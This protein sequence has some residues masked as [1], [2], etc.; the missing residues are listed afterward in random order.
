M[1]FISDY[2]MRETLYKEIVRLLHIHRTW[3]EVIGSTNV[4]KH[5]VIRGNRMTDILCRML[6]VK[7]IYSCPPYRKGTMWQIAEYELDKA[8]KQLRTEYGLPPKAGKGKLTL[9][10]VERIIEIASHGILL[11]KL[12]E[13]PI[14]TNDTD[15]DD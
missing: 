2:R 5:T 6:V 3:L 8:V 9:R 14:F 4:R 13:L 7:A 1:P 11:P 12:C 10:H 15:D